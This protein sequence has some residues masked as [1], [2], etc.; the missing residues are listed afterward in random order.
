[1][2]RNLGVQKRCNIEEGRWDFLYAYKKE[3]KY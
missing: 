2:D 3:E 1:M